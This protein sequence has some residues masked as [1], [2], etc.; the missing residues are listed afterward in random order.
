M[1][2]PNYEQVVV[3]G[4]VMRRI[5]DS[6]YEPQ[7]WGLWSVQR[8]SPKWRQW[9]RWGDALYS[10]RP[11]ADAAKARLDIELFGDQWRVVHTGPPNQ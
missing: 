1:P 4:T 11:A 7:E 3:H 2:T 6:F 5:G 9:E 10:T 8:Y